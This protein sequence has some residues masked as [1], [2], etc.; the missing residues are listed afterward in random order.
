MAFKLKTIP[1]KHSRA[2]YAAETK[3]TMQEVPV[4]HALPRYCVEP[5]GSVKN[6]HHCW[7]LG[8]R[9]SIV[10]YTKLYYTIVYYTK[11]YYTIVYY[12]SL[13]P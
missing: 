6:I 7:D 9:V 11:L 3:A 4:I 12:T 5:S 8:F 13:G 10:Y 1:Q 2:L